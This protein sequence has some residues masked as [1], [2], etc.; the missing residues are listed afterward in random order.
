MRTWVKA[1]WALAATTLAGCNPIVID[2]LEAGRLR[3]RVVLVAGGAR[4]DHAL[5]KELGY[6]AGF[7]P[8][9]TASRVAGFLLEEIT[10]RRKSGEAGA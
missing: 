8:G 1:F 5:A 6:D 2:M 3:D 10:R 7:G 9:T 4:I